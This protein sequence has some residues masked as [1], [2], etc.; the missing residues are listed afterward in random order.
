MA[1]Q[2]QVSDEWL[3]REVAKGRREHLE[4]LI[5]RYATPLMTFVTR[6]VADRHLSE[7]LFQETFLAVWKHRSQYRSPQ[8][9]RS[10][11]FQ[12][13][14]NKCRQ[15]YRRRGDHTA[16]SLDWHAD[17]P[18]SAQPA[19]PLEAAVAAET[20]TMVV[21]AVARLPNQQ[22]A[23]LV[24]RFWNE[25]LFDE[26]AEVLGC[27]AGTARSHMHFAL[28]SMRRYLERRMR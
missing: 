1:A 17:P 21:E 16:V 2:Q 27:T 19:G 7:E 14:V 24:M 20:A 9:F 8:R 11:L 18:V 25:R 13:A 28:A 5:R 15:D 23:V 6:M 3:M 10:W 4:T 22:R 12:I 26:I